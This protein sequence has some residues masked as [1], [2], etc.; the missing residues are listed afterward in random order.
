MSLRFVLIHSP[1]VGPTSWWPVADQLR[2]QQI[3]AVVPSLR[4]EERDQR[5]YWQQHAR[6]VAHELAAI[7]ADQPLMLVGHSGAGP[8]LPAI[9][10]LLPQPIAGY[11]FVDAGL[12]LAGASRLDLL[13]TES[14]TFA[15]ELRQHLEAGAAFPTWSDADLH[16]VIPNPH[17]RRQLLAELRPR[18]LPFFAEPIP[19]FDGWPDAPCA[20]IHLSATY[21][22]YAMQAHLAKWPV[23]TIEADHFHMLV[24]PEVI[25]NLLV[26]AAHS[27]CE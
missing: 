15:T 23:Y 4:D 24:A 16:S 25:A 18:G 5:P 1:L 17:H 13:A 6:S 8:L 14:S 3:A 21:D 2:A 9:R 22:G 7:P 27:I 10:Q 12:P 26:A 20:Y 19:V 11:I